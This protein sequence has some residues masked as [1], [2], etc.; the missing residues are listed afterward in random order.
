M[1]LTPIRSAAAAMVWPALI[2]TVLVAASRLYLQVHFPGDV[3][4]ET[5]AAAL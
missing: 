5:A 3:L 2:A 4:A 1:A